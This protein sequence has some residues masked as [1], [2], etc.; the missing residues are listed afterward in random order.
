[1]WTLDKQDTALFTVAP[2]VLQDETTPTML[3]NIQAGSKVMD[4]KEMG[5]LAF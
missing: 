4:Q 3:K 5:T 1:M 2:F